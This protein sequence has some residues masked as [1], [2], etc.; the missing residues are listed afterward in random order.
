ML[1][2]QPELARRYG[3]NQTS[4]NRAIAVL[5]AEGVV[6]VEHGRGAFVQDVPT[7][8]RIRSIDKD[9][10]SSKT[11]STYAEEMRKAGLPPRAELVE[12]GAT[13]PPAEI[14]E[15]LG[16]GES[17]RTLT[18][19]HMYADDTPVQVAISYIPMRYAGTV[20]L[21][22]PDTGPSG[23]YDR[24]AQRGY[25]P[26][27]FVEDLQ[28]A[29]GAVNDTRSYPD[30]LPRHSVSVGGAVVRADGRVLAI[31]RRDN[32]AWVQPGGVMELS[33]DPH[34]AVR[35]EVLEETG[36]LVEP[37]AL[38]GVYKNMKRGIVS[39][40]F[41]CRYV[42]GTP[43]PTDEAS[44]VAW[45]NREEVIGHMSEAF[46]IRLIDALDGD[47]PRVRIHNGVALL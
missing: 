43:H 44:D 26:V 46:A 18:R 12:V 40:V 22:I 17:D 9:Y 8:K 28:L 25:G 11:G 47:W 15:T 3:L 4:I 31:K 35:R 16:P 10:R 32:G 37:E 23:I 19:R 24:L 5:R 14:A 39:L 36:V 41:R 27:R 38:T 2:S 13:V 42:G 34:E 1:P 6:R 7:V 45:L 21:A 29:A 20:D 33:E 30:D